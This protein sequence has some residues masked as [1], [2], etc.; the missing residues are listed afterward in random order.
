MLVCLRGIQAPIYHS[1]RYTR[2]RTAA[3]LYSSEKAIS[4]RTAGRRALKSRLEETVL[5]NTATAQT[6]SDAE[7]DVVD[8]EN[9]PSARTASSWEP[10]LPKPSSD[11]HHDLSSFLAYAARC[12]L[13]S[14]S[15]TYRGTHYEYTVASALSRFSIKVTRRGGPSDLGVDLV[16]HWDLPAIAQAHPLPVLVQCKARSEKLSPNT[17]R[18]LEGSFVGAPSGWRGEGVLGLLVTPSAATKG[19]REAMGRSEYP[20][21]F[22]KIGIDGR[23]EQFLWNRRA[24]EIGLCGM[25]VTLKYSNGDE[26]SKEIV[27]TWNGKVLHEDSPQDIK[28]KP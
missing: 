6:I 25:G 4:K 12:H 5:V 17:V 15:P 2:F 13:S 18:E 8:L 20:M 28:K 26:L 23:V 10:I 9:R 3:A 7:S 19:A 16:G 14:S 11:N 1:C 24:S 21:G 22:L 27:L